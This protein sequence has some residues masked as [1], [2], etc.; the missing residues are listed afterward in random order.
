MTMKRKAEQESRKAGKQLDISYIY[1]EEGCH[2]HILATP[3]R[4]WI[5]LF[6]YESFATFQKAVYGIYLNTCETTFILCTHIS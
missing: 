4:S 2:M 6:C 1:V 5:T 3:V